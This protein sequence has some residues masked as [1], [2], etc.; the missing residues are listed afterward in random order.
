M[1]DVTEPSP[2]SP[3]TRGRP[4]CRV[5][6]GAKGLVRRGPRVLLVRERHAD[7]SPF[8][9]LP[10]GGVEPEESLA[11]GLRRELAEELDCRS[12]VGEPRSAFPYHHSS[13]PNTVTVYAVFACSLHSEPSP[14]AAEGIEACRWV[15]PRDLP[16]STLP[17]VRRLLGE[18]PSHGTTD[19]TAGADD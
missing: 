3:G 8:W 17:E 15:R 18:E 10:G 16:G 14:R 19:V 6:R 9:T 12:V 1:A 13:L 11:D 5:R 2:G 4:R 7:G